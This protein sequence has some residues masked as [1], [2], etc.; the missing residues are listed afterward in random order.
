MNELQIIEQREVLGKDFKVYGD[1]NNPL[2]MAR[3]VAK[4]I[5]HSDVSTMMRTVDESEKVTNIVCTLGG[6]QEAWFLTEDGLYEVLMQSR[7]PIA[8]QFK[9]K[10]KEI[11]KDIRK[12]GVFAT[13]E[14]LNNPDFLIKALSEL[15]SEREQRTQ[16][17]AQISNDRPKV[18]FAEAVASSKDCVSINELAKLLKQNGMDI[19]QNRL[20]EKMRD[21]GYL[22]TC[23]DTY[24]LPTQRAA[25]M[26][27]FM[28]K[29][30]AIN[31]PN[32]APAIR[33]KTM[34]T[35]KGIKYFI[36]RYLHS[37]LPA[38]AYKQEE[39]F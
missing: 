15:K 22:C 38:S 3:D 31:A 13:E 25:D 32:A 12:Y 19:G 6:S 26:G 27:V 14:L 29:E 36:N 30:T 37:F 33:R 17:E 34:V 20:F 39:L 18:A 23:G 5:E 4:W 9:A 1:I 35:G 10:V 8:K 21:E 16:L 7:K 2:F 24:N 28:V 11:L